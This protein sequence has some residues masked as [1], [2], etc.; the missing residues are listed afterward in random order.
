[1]LLI[2]HLTRD[3]T[4]LQSHTVLKAQ[5]AD[6]VITHRDDPGYVLVSEG[7]LA[8]CTCFVVVHYLFVFYM[9]EGS[10]SIYL[11]IY[12]FIYNIVQLLL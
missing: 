3:R 9:F 7:L 12:L 8:Y 11:S 1:M 6:V 2:A 10:P 4:R 5:I